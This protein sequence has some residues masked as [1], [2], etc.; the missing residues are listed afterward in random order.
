MSPGINSILNTADASFIHFIAAKQNPKFISFK[1]GVIRSLFFVVL[2]FSCS[3]GYHTIWFLATVFSFTWEKSHFEL[4]L[5][6]SFSKFWTDLG[7][8]SPEIPS[9]SH[10]YLEYQWKD[11]YAKENAGCMIWT[12]SAI[13]VKNLGSWS[14]LPSEHPKSTSS[15]HFRGYLH[16]RGA[17]NLH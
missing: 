10:Y 5:S 9:Q 4:K 15:F 17:K 16:T 14:Q 2:W 3:E 1:Y 7:K 11:A 6:I 8:P 13:L 12:K